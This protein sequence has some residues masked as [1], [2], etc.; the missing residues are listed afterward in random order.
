MLKLQQG[1]TALPPLV[2]YKPVTV[3]G[4]ASA[5]AAAA[6][7]ATASD[8]SKKGTD[9]TDKDLLKMLEKL[10]GL[11]SDMTVLTKT[12][13]NFYIDQ[14]YSPFPSTSNI[15]SKYLQT[16]YQMK[17]AKFNKEEYQ[18]A[19][20][21]VNSNGGINEY[22]ISDRGQLFCMGSNGD[23]KLL[24]IDQMKENP[25]YQPLTNSEVLNFRAQY[26]QMANKN[27]LIKVVKNGIGMEAVTKMIQ[28]SIG[29]LGSTSESS[30]GYVKTQANQL[31][32]GLQEFMYAQQQAGNYVA[33]VDNLYKGKYL[34][35]SQAK[36][37]QAALT[38]IYTTLPAN[39]K[40]LLKTKTA[41]GTDEEAVQLVQTLIN[42]RLN[43]T[44][45]FSLD[46]DSPNSGSGK[47]GSKSG[48]DVNLVS[49]IQAGH[50]GH[51]TV[52]ELDNASG[53]SMTVDGTAYEQ[54]KDTKGNHIGGTSVDNLLNN[55]GLRS[56]INADS[57]IYFGNQKIDLDNL[58]KIAYDG[59]GV[60]RANL[61]IRADGSPNFDILEEYSKAQAE[62]LLSD[63]TNEDRLAIFGDAEKFP[64]LNNLITE[65]GELDTTKFAPFII[66]SGITTDHLTKLS[67]DNTFITKKEQTD[68]NVKFLKN[69]LATGTAAKPQYPDIDETSMF[70]IAGDAWVPGF[71]SDWIVKGN[72]YI[73]L[74]MNKTSAILGGNQD[75]DLTIGNTLEEEYQKRNVRVNKV[76][77][78]ILIN[79]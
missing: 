76:D 21:T 42:A 19:L 47:S 68:D 51:E 3:T 27:D 17:V 33:T 28:N 61:P 31:I 62:F 55:S 29:N 30:E 9:L 56:I 24:T 11:P 14:Q 6:P 1:G 72:I 60:L 54:V 23:F 64:N 74:N 59:K 20:A 46:M 53:V 79:N 13:Q 49:M 32:S 52:Y 4:G 70:E 35:K 8:D 12:L 2:S 25:D 40:T 37:A 38:Y 44:S 34:T 78:S 57:G 71:G 39:A 58:T 48:L 5:P 66:A 77:P 26:P 67:D 10:D 16:L 73:P 43:S 36:Q 22:A 41:N 45:E 69:S 15:A 63:Q 50:G 7:A 75:V 18:S 65:D